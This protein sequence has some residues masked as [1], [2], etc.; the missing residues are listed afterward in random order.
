[1]AAL[2]GG[3][4]GVLPVV[5]TKAM[6]RMESRTELR[7]RVQALDIAKKRVEFVNAWMGARRSCLPR[8]SSDGTTQEALRELDEIR[9]S[10][11]QAL[12][13]PSGEAKRYKDRSLIQR[14]L[15]AYKPKHM[16]GW[17]WRVAY[18]MWT[19]AVVS[20]LLDGISRQGYFTGRDSDGTFSVAYL[21]GEFTGAFLLFLFSWFFHRRA[22]R[23]DSGPN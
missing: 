14:V 7:Q 21:I 15:L 1:M 22:V 2:I 4:A 12:E 5:V 18:Y 9:V 20:S 13:V 10:L 8:D 11:K 3:A 16:A 17:W 19:G 23:S 6:S